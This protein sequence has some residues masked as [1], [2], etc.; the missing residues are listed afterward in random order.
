MEE[1]ERVD[2]TLL[3]ELAQFENRERRQLLIKIAN[4]L[5]KNIDDWLWKLFPVYF[6]EIH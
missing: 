2:T 5:K 1:D 3:L 4:W 6:R